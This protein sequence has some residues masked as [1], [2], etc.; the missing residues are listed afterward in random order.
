ML[1]ARRCAD[2]GASEVAA[3]LGLP[4]WRAE[5]LT[6]QTRSYREDELVSAMGVLAE[7][8]LE[9]KGGESPEAALERAVV[10]IIGAEG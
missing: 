2:K 5:R 1:R 9:L 6:K 7:T 10:Q 8:D 4:D 3:L